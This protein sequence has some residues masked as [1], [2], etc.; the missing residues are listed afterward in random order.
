MEYPVI[1]TIFDNEGIGYIVDLYENEELYFTKQFSDLLDFS[2]RGSFSKTFRIPASERN[3]VSFGALYNVN[4]QTW[5]DFRRKVPATLT[6]QTIPISEGHIQVKTVYSNNDALY[7]Y[8]IIFFGEAI[9]VTK[10]IG[11]KL[12]N[13]LDY[14]S[15][16]HDLNYQNILDI[17]SGGLF[18]ND[19]CYTLT[20]KGFNFAE[21][22]GYRRVFDPA[23]PVQQSEL[24]LAIRSLWLFSKILDEA[25]VQYNLDSGM[26][27]ELKKMYT[28]FITDQSVLSNLTPQESYFTVAFS[29]NFFWNFAALGGN[30]TANLPAPN[31]AY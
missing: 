5:F 3:V 27:D 20:D 13:Q 24:T 4:V 1:L 8:E 10:S 29:N 25:G 9:D 12:L 17:N 19:I 23:N 2:S 28:P 14:S 30:T 26:Y 11:D 31:T 15:L 18:G 6:V 7:E 16:A 21:V 22:A